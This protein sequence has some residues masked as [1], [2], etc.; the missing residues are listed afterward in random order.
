MDLS[1]IPGAQQAVNYVVQQVAA[2]ESLPT[3]LQRINADAMAVQNVAAQRG[4]QQTA[5]AMGSV[6]SGTGSVLDQVNTSAP[7]I[8]Q[9]IAAVQAGTIDTTVVATALRLAAMMAS[10]FVATRT[11][12]Q[13]VSQAAAT[14]LTADQRA[15][16]GIGAPAPGLS[17][18][19]TGAV[20]VVGLVGL[21]LWIAAR[22]RRRGR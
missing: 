11:L 1:Q 19:T 20:V 12:Q 18:S 21:G 13:A 16:L 22:R 15:A 8:G 2:W 17:S 4:D 5:N 10:G 7:L 14:T 3:T 6:L 9:V